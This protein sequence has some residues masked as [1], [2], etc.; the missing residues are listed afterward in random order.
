M[1]DV[2]VFHHALGLTAGVIG[3]ADALRSAGHT[4]Y[5]PDLFEGRLFPDLE[6]GVAHAEEVGFGTIAQRGVDAVTDLPADLVY[7]GFSLGVLPA[8]K[9]AQTLRG[10]AG[11]ILCH[12]AVPIDSFGD[13]WPNGV[14]VQIHF[15]SGDPWAEEDVEA[16]AAL[17]DEAG[18]EIFEYPGS[19]HLFADPGHPDHDPGASRLL[20]E[21]VLE[22]LARLS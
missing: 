19:S 13:D 7:A 22:F 15:M 11:A 14:P 12:S 6:A 10:V 3:F 18:A 2:V 21:R 17:R 9:A 5:T 1:A 4:V 16:I 20:L 8:Q